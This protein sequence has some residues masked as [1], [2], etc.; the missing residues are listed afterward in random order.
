VTLTATD[1]EGNAG[2]STATI[3]ASDDVSPWTFSRVGN[4]GLEGGVFADDSDPENIVYSILAG[5]ST[6]G[7]RSDHGQYLHRRLAG[8]FSVSVKID[9]ADLARSTSARVG[10]MARENLEDDAAMVLM[11]LERS[12]DG[13]VFRSRLTAGATA[14]NEA[15]SMD[16]PRAGVPVWLRLER[17]GAT[18]IGS[19]SSDGETY[20]EYARKDVPA[21]DVAELE[22]G[23]GAV[24]GSSSLTTTYIVSELEGFDPPQG[25]PFHRG[26]ADGSG[27]LQLTDGVFILSWLFVQ[28]GTPPCM[29]AADSDDSESIELTD[30]V[31]ILS[32][33]FLGGPPP[34]E[35]GPPG[36]PCGLDAAGDDGLGCETYTS[37]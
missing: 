30:A 13:W 28:G 15:T 26:D 21:L 34:V 32:F 8:N 19:V 37:C 23:V 1:D 35:P 12:N 14:R 31:L 22:I 5:G 29:N 7:S 18:F 3:I 4:R 27:D 25:T 2:V 11:A 6:F 36:S 17:Q 20:E 24:A 10:L 33:L 9:Q 16:P